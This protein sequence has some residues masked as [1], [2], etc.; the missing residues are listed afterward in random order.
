VDCPVGDETS[1]G[2]KLGGDITAGRRPAKGI[3]GRLSCN[4]DFGK[5]DETANPDSDRIVGLLD[6]KAAWAPVGANG[7]DVFDLEKQ[8]VIP[9]RRV[10][11]GR[12]E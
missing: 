3:G 10:F 1:S 2:K 5:I 8:W 12:V 7:I 4:G 9:G 6:E 11:E